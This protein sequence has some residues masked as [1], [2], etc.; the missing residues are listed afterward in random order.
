MVSAS[1]KVFVGFSCVMVERP[2][3]LVFSSLIS[4]ISITEC[5][6]EGGAII[7]SSVSLCD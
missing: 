7:G 4:T 5:S 2:A 1:T 6:G 3:M